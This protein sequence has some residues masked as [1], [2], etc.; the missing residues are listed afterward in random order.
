MRRLLLLI[1]FCPLLV[2]CL[3]TVDMGPGL[4]K[5]SFGFSESMRWSDYPGAAT[6]VHPDV[7][8]YFLEQFQED[9]DFHVVESSISSVTMDVS[10]KQADVVYVLK[11]YRLPSTRIQ[12]WRWEQQW[13]LIQEKVTKSGVWLIENEP[14]ALPWKQ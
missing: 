8:E 13:Q 5:I 1:F 12:K 7:R 10:G 6:Y 4:G 11:Y 3:G 2:S 9:E 14:P